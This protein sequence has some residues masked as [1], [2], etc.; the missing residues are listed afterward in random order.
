MPA[1][2]VSSPFLVYRDGGG[3]QQLVALESRRER[4]TVGRGQQTDLWLDWDTQA[5]RLHAAFERLGGDW[6]VVDDGLS[7]NG[8]YVNGD[9]VEGR[10]RLSDGDVVRC[11]NTELLF[12]TP[13]DD[14][15]GMTV[16]P[17]A[18][19][20]L[21]DLPPTRTVDATPVAALAEAAPFAQ[22]ERAEL[23]RVAA[24]AVPRRYGAGEALFREGDL[25]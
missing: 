24:V 18:S 11:G 23:E 10:R 2:V 15:R 7:R 17:G 4:L 13:A 21:P 20:A 1:T 9:R 16:E 12:Q 22:L 5:S 25:G 8:T 6:T 19:A 3:H 14:R